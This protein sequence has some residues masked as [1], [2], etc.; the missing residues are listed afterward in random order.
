[1]RKYVSES[2][3]NNKNR[4]YCANTRLPP[5]L[6]QFQQFGDC[7]FKHSFGLQW[8]AVLTNQTYHLGG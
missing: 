7:H 4:I 3:T 1:M 6:K 5:K 8:V 2:F